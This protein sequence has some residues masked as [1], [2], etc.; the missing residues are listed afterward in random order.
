MCLM[1]IFSSKQDK[2][3]KEQIATLQQQVK[4]LQSTNSNQGIQGPQG[5]QGMPGKDGQPGRDGRNGTGF[6]DY[7][8]KEGEDMYET[9]QSIIDSVPGGLIQLPRGTYFSSKPLL[10][11]NKTIW[12]QGEGI[13]ST[14][15][16]F[17]ATSGLR[18]SRVGSLARSKVNG[19]SIVSYGEKVQGKHGIEVETLVDVS[20]VYI[21]NFGSNGIRYYGN[22][23]AGSDVSGCTGIN[24][25]V[26]ECGADGIYI[27]GGDANALSFYGCNARDNGG[28]GFQDNG[29]LGSYFFGCMGHN[30][31]R[32]NIGVGDNN[33]S[34]AV[35]SGFYSEGGSPLSQ[36]ALY[37]TVIGGTWG[38]GFKIGQGGF[39]RH[40]NYLP[41]EGNQ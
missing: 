8:L 22:I 19:L 36:I 7:G 39:E 6:I 32:G 12:L 23:G 11:H 24:I 37:T 27:E 1:S 28:A 3:F 34:R 26:A 17:R 4:L 13:G 41:L 2:I 25:E 21:K 30:N 29:F 20:D 5:P 16:A 10:V 35:I 31:N 9:L 38:S 14:T 33:N 40:G 15:L 18:F